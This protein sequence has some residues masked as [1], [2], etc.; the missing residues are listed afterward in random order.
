[1]SPVTTRT[2]G[3]V[4]ALLAVVLAESLVG[5]QPPDRVVD[6]DPTAREGRVV[7]D[8]LGGIKLPTGFAAPGGSS[9]RMEDRD[10]DI[11]QI[12]ERS[13]ARWQPLQ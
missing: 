8:I 2:R 4:A 10:P 3:V 12:P 1:M 11:A 7:G 5:A 13:H 9:P 6:E